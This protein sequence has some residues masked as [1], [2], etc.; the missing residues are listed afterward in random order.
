MFYIHTFLFDGWK[1]KLLLFFQGWGMMGAIPRMA[2]GG[3]YGPVGGVMNVPQGCN[4]HYHQQ[5]G[6][7]QHCTPTSHACCD[8]HHRFPVNMP[9]N[10]NN[11]GPN[12]A[13]G[14]GI[15]PGIGPGF[16]E[17]VRPNMCRPGDPSMFRGGM[18]QGQGPLQQ[19]QQSV[20]Q[21]QQQQQ[22]QQ[23]QQ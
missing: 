8:N 18:P 10:M 16:G 19:Q 17:M 21:L 13:M 7:A 3:G 15:R 2:G 6:P 22:Q 14:P 5:H 1:G 4:H 11:M 12:M 9:S 20:Q 23:L